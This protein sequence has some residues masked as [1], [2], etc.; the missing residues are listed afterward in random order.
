MKSTRQVMDSAA[1]STNG[2]AAGVTGAAFA[3]TATS[4][5]DNLAHLVTIKNNTANDHSAKTIAIV[6]TDEN[7]NAQ[8]ENIAAPGISA[9]VTSTKYFKT[10][11]SVTP[12]STIGVD[13]FD[14]G[15]AAG[16]RGP[17][18]QPD[19]NGGGEFN[20]GI[21]CTVVSGSPNFGLVVSYDRV[22]WHAHGTIAGK[23]A[24]FGGQQATPV[25][26]MAVQ[27]TA[28]GAVTATF[29]QPNGR[30]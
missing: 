1:A 7:G 8:S 22:S 28:A 14:I 20:V 10:L 6:G 21:G 23:T 24:S 4:I 3:L 25:L 5:S 16:S 11:T 13:T 30:D 19:M 17:W 9:T 15:W 18:F 12:S 27:F 26:A 2:F 29:L